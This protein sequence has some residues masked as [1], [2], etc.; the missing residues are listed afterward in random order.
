MPREIGDAPLQ[1]P[2]ARPRTSRLDGERFANTVAPHHIEKMEKPATN[3]TMTVLYLVPIVGL[4]IL[5]AVGAFLLLT[6]T[7]PDDVPVRSAD[8][9]YT[10][11]K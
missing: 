7:R 4:P 5:A 8:P 9:A 6:S 2:V 3:W 1:K 11:T 10:R